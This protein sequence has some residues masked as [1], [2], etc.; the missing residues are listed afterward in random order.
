MELEIEISHLAVI[1]HIYST[2]KY[3]SL[4]LNTENIVQ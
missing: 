2:S 3:V 4:F 1:S